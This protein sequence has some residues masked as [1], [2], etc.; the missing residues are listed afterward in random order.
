M[1]STR[2]SPPRSAIP[3]WSRPAPELDRIFDGGC[4]LTEGVAAGHDGM[5]YFSDITFTTFCKDPSGKF[6][7]AGHIWKYDPKTGK[8]TIFR[9]PPAC[10]TAS[11]STATAT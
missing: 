5:V 8:T 9:S 4:V 10:P 11:S 2:A 7:Q 1:R 6:P 3:A